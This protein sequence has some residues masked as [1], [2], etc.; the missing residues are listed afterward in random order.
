MPD[1]RRNLNHLILA[2]TFVNGLGQF[3]VTMQLL[4]DLLNG[5]DRRN[6]SGIWQ[7]SAT[8]CIS[9]SASWQ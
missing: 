6:V 2:D 9:R 5:P 7:D 1:P 4:A 3:P 8:G